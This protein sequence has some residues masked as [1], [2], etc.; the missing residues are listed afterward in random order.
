MSSTGSVWYVGSS[1]VVKFYCCW[2]WIVFYVESCGVSSAKCWVHLVGVNRLSACRKFLGVI[3]WQNGTRCRDGVNVLWRHSYLIWLVFEGSIPTCP[4]FHSENFFVTCSC[5]F[6][7][8]FF[9]GGGGAF[10]ELF[11]EMVRE[12]RWERKVRGRCT[13][14]KV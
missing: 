4:C 10:F 6:F 9:L 13:V 14:Y 8:F 1:Y 7:L 12:E 11:L 3:S 2:I 5:C